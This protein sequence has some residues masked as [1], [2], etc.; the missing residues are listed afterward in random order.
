MRQFPRPDSLHDIIAT[1][2]VPRRKYEQDKLDVSRHYLKDLLQR[3]LRKRTR[4]GSPWNRL[5]LWDKNLLDHFLSSGI[6]YET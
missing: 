6:S 5:E 4:Q 3:F 2:L 1:L